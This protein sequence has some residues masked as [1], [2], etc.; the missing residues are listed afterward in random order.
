M[1][2]GN[3]PYVKN[4]CYLYRKEA[5]AHKMFQ[6]ITS[7]NEL[8]R[9]EKKSQNVKYFIIPQR[10]AQP[11]TG[12]KIPQ[13]KLEQPGQ[14]PIIICPLSLRGKWKLGLTSQRPI[15]PT[16][17]DGSVRGPVSSERW[18]SASC[19]PQMNQATHLQVTLHQVWIP[20]SATSTS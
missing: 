12:N 6:N 7:W 9:K 19:H 1:L 18:P 20:V 4:K 11:E 16:C 15:C 10:P 2:I 5:D 14:I 13:I 3:N 8:V 17:Q